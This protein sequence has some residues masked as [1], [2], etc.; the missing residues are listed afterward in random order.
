MLLPDG[1]ETMISEGTSLTGVR[2][3]AGSGVKRK[4]DC[5]DVLVQR[6]GGKRGQ[7]KKLRGTGYVDDLGMSRQCELHW[8]EGGDGKRVDMKVKRFYY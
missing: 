2:V 7:W 8:Y 3:I 1:S 6:Y 5:E 4:I